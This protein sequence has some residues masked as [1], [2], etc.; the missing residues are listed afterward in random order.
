MHTDLSF[1]G[2]VHPNLRWTRKAVTLTLNVGRRGSHRKYG[3]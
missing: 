2:L 1:V 3:D